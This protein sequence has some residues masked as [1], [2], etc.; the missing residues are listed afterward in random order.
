MFLE[1]VERA[2][3]LTPAERLE[4]GLLLTER[5]FGL[6][7]DGLRHRFPHESPEQRL[8]RLCRQLDLAER[9][10]GRHGC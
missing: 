10:D 8:A 3:R 7:L 1:E 4:E 5:A 9:R 2:R 6:A